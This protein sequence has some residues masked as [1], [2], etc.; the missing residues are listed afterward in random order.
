MKRAMSSAPLVTFALQM[1]C[2]AVIDPIGLGACAQ[3]RGEGFDLGW[4]QLPA[5]DCGS[6]NGGPQTPFLS[7]ATR[8]HDPPDHWLF[9][10]AL[11]ANQRARFKSE[12]SDLLVTFYLVWQPHALAFWQTEN[13][14][15][16]AADVYANDPIP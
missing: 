7:T 5:R 3:A 13:I 2:R 12:S 9:L 16:I 6:V 14:Q 1:H 8:T 4:R 15:P 10:A 11:E